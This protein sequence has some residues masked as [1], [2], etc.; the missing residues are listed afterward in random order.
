MIGRA[1]EKIVALGV[2]VLV[3]TISLAQGNAIVYPRRGGPGE[4]R[5][6]REQVDADCLDAKRFLRQHAVG[7]RSEDIQQMH[8]LTAENWAWALGW[9]SQE[10]LRQE[11]E[12]ERER[13][14]RREAMDRAIAEAASGVI[15]ATR[16]REAAAR[17]AWGLR[18]RES[19]DQS[20]PPPV[21]W[22]G[23][24][25]P[26]AAERSQTP[27]ATGPASHPGGGWRQYGAF[28]IW[29]GERPDVQMPDDPYLDRFS[30]G[31]FHDSE[32]AD[33]LEGLGVNGSD[34]ADLSQGD[35]PSHRSDPSRLATQPAWQEWGGVPRSRGP[36]SEELARAEAARRAAEAEAE[37]QR[38]E[39]ARR[40]RERQD[41]LITD[42]VGDQS[43][44]GSVVDE[45]L[46]SINAP[47]DAAREGNLID[48]VLG[49]V[50]STSSKALR[51]RPD[52]SSLIDDVLGSIGSPD[53]VDQGPITKTT[54]SFMDELLSPTS[55][56][57]AAVT[58]RGEA[59][60]GG[61]DGTANEPIHTPNLPP[62]LMQS[63]PVAQ[64]P[65]AAPTRSAADVFGDITSGRAGE[66]LSWAPEMPSG[67]ASTQ[68]YTLKSQTARVVELHMST[69]SPSV[70]YVHSGIAETPNG[71]R[72]EYRWYTRSK[73]T[74]RHATVGELVK[75]NQIMLMSA[76]GVEPAADVF[77]AIGGG[78]VRGISSAAGEVIAEQRAG[79]PGEFTPVK[80]YV[81]GK[82]V[83]WHTKGR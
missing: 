58:E 40:E 16:T 11:Q 35:I 41:E 9:K 20:T 74:G 5:D 24:P 51:P 54:R 62:E 26:G 76:S 48:D 34:Y 39:A 8:C 65:I 57:R 70:L 50:P 77:D 81:D 6:F 44:G 14:A 37:R 79:G 23:I 31:H 60:S 68:P 32:Y 29:E 82:A 13:R 19:W 59:G 56:N 69:E 17:A 43:S 36:S 63:G 45:V 67:S 71:E 75:K 72:A 47:G 21:F 27:D 1:T 66:R 49:S 78:S 22:P 3:P 73:T 83:E 80:L 38:E 30:G 4:N 61:G 52:S 53:G 28:T 18:T 7:L 46:G 25:G 55:S 10:E 42:I 12:A 33:M 64:L 2:L 15:A